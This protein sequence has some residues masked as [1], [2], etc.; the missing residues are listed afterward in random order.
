MN[1]QDLN[2]GS[3]SAAK[4]LKLLPLQPVDVQDAN[5]QMN[6]TFGH[7]RRSNDLTAKLR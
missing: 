7:T 5:F 2:L 4:S 6:R 3:N 1:A